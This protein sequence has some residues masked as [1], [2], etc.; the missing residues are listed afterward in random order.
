MI[1]LHDVHVGITLLKSANYS[2]CRRQQQS[3]QQNFREGE[4][5]NVCIRFHQARCI[6]NTIKQE[7]IFH[8]ACYICCRN[9]VCLCSLLYPMFWN[10]DNK[11]FF[12]LAGGDKPS[13]WSCFI[14]KQRTK[15][16]EPV[17]VFFYCNQNNRIV[18]KRQLPMEKLLKSQNQSF[19]EYYFYLCV[20]VLFLCIFL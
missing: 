2:I 10:G 20:C 4:K 3:R 7:L 14:F 15:R 8:P 9:E 5:H 11:I 13:V 18:S 1:H 17:G 12:A 19:N 6:I 16:D